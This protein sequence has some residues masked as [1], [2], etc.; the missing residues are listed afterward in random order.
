M[1]KYIKAISSAASSGLGC[2]LWLIMIF[3]PMLIGGLIVHY[4]NN[5]PEKRHERQMIL[6]ERERIAKESHEHRLAFFNS[7]SNE[8][9]YF[10]EYEEFDDWLSRANYAAI[11]LL[12]GVYSE[13]HDDFNGPDGIRR[14]AD[15][16]FWTAPEY[17]LDL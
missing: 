16:L 2:I 8:H 6:D 13:N 4:C 12:H 9:P 10:D 3:S 11:E 14:M 5:T 7:L 17:D 15:Y 1:G